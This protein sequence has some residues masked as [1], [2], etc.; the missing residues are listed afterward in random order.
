MALMYD[1][2]RMIV[3]KVYSEIAALEVLA[4]ETI[5]ALNENAVEVLEH[6]R[7]GFRGTFSTACKFFFM[8]LVCDSTK[9]VTRVFSSR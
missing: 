3:E 5:L 6:V 1:R 2:Q 4:E 9:V 8:F 7:Y